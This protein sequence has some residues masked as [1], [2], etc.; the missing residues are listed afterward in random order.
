MGCPDFLILPGILEKA[1]PEDL[2]SIFSDLQKAGATASAL[3]VCPS[4]ILFLRHTSICPST[5]EASTSF[6][7]IH[8]VDEFMKPDRKPDEY[9]LLHQFANFFGHANSAITELDDLQGWFGRTA[10]D[11]IN[12]GICT[13]K[14]I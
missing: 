9:G 7:P 2:S 12:K 11:L 5:H 8:E 10:I 1:V 3:F 14:N 4:G 6:D 13:R